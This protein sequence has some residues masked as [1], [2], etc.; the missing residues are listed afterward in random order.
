[1]LQ[2][3]PLQTSVVPARDP[4]AGDGPA[5]KKKSK[6]Q[7]KSKLTNGKTAEVEVDRAGMAHD[8]DTAAA[9]EGAVADKA[10]PGE[11]AVGDKDKNG[12]G[13]KTAGD[14]TVEDKT[15]EDKAVEDKTVEDKTG[16]NVDAELVREL[17]T[18]MLEAQVGDDLNAFGLDTRAFRTP[19]NL[20]YYIKQYGT[21]LFLA[22]DKGARWTFKPQ[23][24]KVE[25]TGERSNKFIKF[26][27]FSLVLYYIYFI[28][29][30]FC[31][32]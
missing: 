31:I 29:I 27:C 24:Y 13:D 17:D 2:E 16:I 18:P 30:D 12:E 15:V 14:K 26:K 4:G 23:D 7:K 22:V 6:K 10:A 9:G 32:F 25:V 21:I 20:T 8:P 28:K 3:K 19:S 11:D 1:M 5:A